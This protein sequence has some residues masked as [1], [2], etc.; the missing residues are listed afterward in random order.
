M[1]C[2]FQFYWQKKKES[3]SGKT[4]RD[5]FELM[6]NEGSEKQDRLT[7]YGAAEGSA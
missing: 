4:W 5:I 3:K 7:G 6:Q 1:S 2:R